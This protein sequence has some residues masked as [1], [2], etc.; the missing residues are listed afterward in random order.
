[1]DEDVSEGYI[2]GILIA[3]SMSSFDTFDK[4]DSLF[5]ILNGLGNGDTEVL[6]VNASSLIQVGIDLFSF[7]LV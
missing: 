7:N 1:L 3:G 6:R 2:L 5:L 4:I